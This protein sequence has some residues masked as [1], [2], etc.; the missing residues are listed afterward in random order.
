MQHIQWIV[1]SDV[2]SRVYR[3]VE[4]D[5]LQKKIINQHDF[6]QI[7]RNAHWVHRPI[8]GATGS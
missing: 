2:I 4:L 8:A 5:R 7:G 6:F 1:F 3:R